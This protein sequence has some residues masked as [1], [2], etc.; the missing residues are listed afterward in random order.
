MQSK[1]EIAADV[2][3]RGLDDWVALG[4]VAWVV[5]YRTNLQSPQ[6]I[7]DMT[8]EVVEEMLN[9]EYALVGDLILL[10]DRKKIE[11]R[12]WNL[13]TAEAIERIDT[14]WEEYG[15]P[16]AKTHGSDVCWLSNTPK[17]DDFVKG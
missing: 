11:F 8:K 2:L 10:E 13:S 4:E 7:K 16:T 1:E 17:G 15:G 14:L 6:R 12:P 3:D 9:N 5:R